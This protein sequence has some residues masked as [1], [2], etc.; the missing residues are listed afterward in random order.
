MIIRTNHIIRAV[1]EIKKMAVACYRKMY[2]AKKFVSVSSI[3]YII[4]KS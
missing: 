2:Y 4:F 3:D 1:K